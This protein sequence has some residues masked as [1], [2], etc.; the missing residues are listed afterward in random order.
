ML[1]DRIT[2]GF[3]L[4]LLLGAPCFIAVLRAGLAA[5]VGNNRAIDLGAHAE[6]PVDARWMH[7]RIVDVDLHG[8]DPRG[9]LTIKL[10][11]GLGPSIPEAMTGVRVGTYVAPPTLQKATPPAKAPVQMPTPTPRPVQP[12][13]GRPAPAPV[14]QG[15]PPP[16]ASPPRSPSGPPLASTNL[17]LIVHLHAEGSSLRVEPGTMAREL[18]VFSGWLSGQVGTIAALGALAIIDRVLR[19]IRFTIPGLGALPRLAWVWLAGDGATQPALALLANLD[20]DLR[21]RHDASRPPASARGN[22]SAVRNH[23]PPNVGVRLGV[24][25]ATFARLQTAAF[26]ATPS[27]FGEGE[28]GVAYLQKLE[29]FLCPAQPGYIDIRIQFEIETP[30][31]NGTLALQVPVEPRAQAGA[32]HWRVGPVARETDVHADLWMTVA[33]T[34]IGTGKLFGA[35]TPWVGQILDQG[36]AQLG[37]WLARAL[38][39]LAGAL[40]ARFSVRSDNTDVALTV[41][42]ESVSI[43]AAGASFHFTV[44][45]G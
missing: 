2:S 24:A 33:N 40:P 15:P 14:P 11:V 32:L 16:E 21:T 36:G 29:L 18:A 9:D 37:Q 1:H 10:R 28:F 17:A 34:L 4:E 8:N 30:G 20:L 45:G 44:Q 12:G 42:A 13:L 22:A 31:L 35:Q 39:P 19:S 43:D 25:R 5:I 41:G 7:L 26:W 38:Q 3:D 6:V 23:L 27:R